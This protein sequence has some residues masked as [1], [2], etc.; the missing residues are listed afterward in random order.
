MRSSL[1]R[2]FAFGLAAFAAAVSLGPS[3][4]ADPSLPGLPNLDFLSY[5]GASPK[6]YF[7]N[8][9]P[10]GWTGGGNLIFI[11]T[12]GNS[13]NPNTACGSIYL[14]TYGCP[15]TL[16]INGGNYNYVEADGNPMY[17]NSFSYLVTGLT[18]GTT[19]TLSFYQAASQQT[20]FG[21]PLNT[22]EQ[23]IVSLGTDPLSLACCGPTS[24]T[25]GPTDYYYDN[26]PSAS[27][28]ATPLMTTPSGGL[29]DWN[30]VSV[31]LTADSTSDL[32]S[33]LAWGDDG[34]TINLPPIVFLTGVDSGAGYAPSLVPEPGTLV[35]YGAGLLAFG[36]LTLRRRA[37]GASAA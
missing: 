21:T 35:L 23:W 18:P 37:K 26:D 5:T 22:T 12:P 30:Y 2:S 31:N 1:L 13:S 6:N 29:T 24:A 10:T 3:A 11:D 15:S 33:F 14:T 20:G 16:G 28:A 27:I 25:Y 7:T 8:V 34:S 17:E 19:Y 4:H 9:D 32:L 36:W